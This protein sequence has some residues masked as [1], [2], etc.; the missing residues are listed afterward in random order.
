M[1]TVIQDKGITLSTQVHGDLEKILLM[2]VLNES[3]GELSCL[4]FASVHPLVAYTALCKMVGR[5]SI[6]SPT[7][8]IEEVPRYDHDDLANIFRWASDLIR[9]L[10]NSVKEDECI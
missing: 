7:S 3:Y 5:C 10:I 4:A 8:A 1:S 6:F 2:H 9:K